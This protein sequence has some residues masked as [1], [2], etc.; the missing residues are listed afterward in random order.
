[1][2]EITNK[3]IL[4]TIGVILPASG[5]SSDVKTLLDMIRDLGGKKAYEIPLIA[6]RG[7]IHDNRV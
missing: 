4:D 2:V 1:M 5:T 7:E 3:G 6:G